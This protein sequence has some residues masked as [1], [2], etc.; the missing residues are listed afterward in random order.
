M[1]DKLKAIEQKHLEEKKNS[2]KEFDDFKMKVKEREA[3]LE[4]EQQQKLEDYKLDVLDAKKK[5]ESRVD[6]L[7]K[8]LDEHRKNNEALDEMK[9]AHQK[10][11]AAY[12]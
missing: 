7:R 2:Q 10:E 3:F 5:F 1:Q 9:K 6:D 4:K 8:Q 11:L 12:I